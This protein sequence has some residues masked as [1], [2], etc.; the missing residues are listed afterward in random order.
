[1]NKLKIAALLALAGTGIFTQ[2]AQAVTYT[3]G[4]VLIGFRSSNSSITTDY[5]IDVGQSLFSRAAAN[6][7]SI[8]IGNFGTDL[9]SFDPTW[10]TDGTTLWGVG[11]ANLTGDNSRTLYA[12]YA[13]NSLNPTPGTS[14]NGQTNS[15]STTQQG[16]YNT[17]GTLFQQ[18]T[19]A[20][21]SP[22]G[23]DGSFGYTGLQ[24]QLQNSGNASSWASQVN[25]STGVGFQHFVGFEGG[26]G[27]GSL[28]DG[29]DYYKINPSPSTPSLQGTFSVDSTGTI[30]FST[31]VPE[32]STLAALIGGAGFLG[33]I[34]R[35]RTALA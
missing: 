21:G 12:G 35:R 29:I 3:Q 7:G 34:R 1:M 13:Q 17:V 16:R 4:D 14:Y 9:S 32:P 31:P 22:V 24:V 26:V 18:G 20:T 8:T 23:D 15:A 2:T 27:A 25:F 6:G 19:A 11:G 10:F 33:L 30:T 5:L 28:G